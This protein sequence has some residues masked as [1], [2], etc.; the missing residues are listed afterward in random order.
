MKNLR[1]DDEGLLPILIGAAIAGLLG[2]SWLTDPADPW[3]LI[4]VYVVACLLFVIGL[5]ALMG[6]LVLLGRTVSF[7]IG[8]GCVGFAIYLVYLG[9]FPSLGV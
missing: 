8:L 4:K 5:Y 3:E 2:F 9:K 1:A 6:K 7:V